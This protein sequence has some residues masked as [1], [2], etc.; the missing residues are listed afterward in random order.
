MFRWFAISLIIEMFMS[1]TSINKPSFDAGGRSVPA[2]THWEA[3]SPQVWW[4]ARVMEAEFI[5]H[6]LPSSWTVGIS[7]NTWRPLESD[8][9]PR[10]AISTES[11]WYVPAE[12][13]WSVVSA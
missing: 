11:E 8:V 13:G 9:F 10:K 1:Y 3:F 5:R 4:E 6:M 2:H 7:V 12:C